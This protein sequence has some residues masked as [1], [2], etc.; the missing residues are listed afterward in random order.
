MRN[1]RLAFSSGPINIDECRREDSGNAQRGVS[2]RCLLLS[3]A[4]FFIVASSKVQA[5][6]IAGSLPWEPNG[7]NPP[8]AAKLG[9]WQFFSGVEGR[10]MEALA[11]R[12]IPP[13]QQTPGGKESGCAVFIDRQLAGPY[14]DQEGLYLKPPFQA[15]ASRPS[16][17]RCGVSTCPIKEWMVDYNAV[18]PHSLAR[19][20][21]TSRVSQS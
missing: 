14:G 11:D 19:L 20:L 16:D 9:P 3:T 5:R 10:A 21:P 8:L 4:T 6:I 17:P 2:R 1:L 15:G 7:G 12:I 18:Y 13:D